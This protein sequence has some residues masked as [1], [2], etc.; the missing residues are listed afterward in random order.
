MWV[1]EAWQD[2]EKVWFPVVWEEKKD[3][4]NIIDY[5]I[6]EEI[7]IDTS[8]VSNANNDTTTGMATVIPWVNA[9]KLIESTSIYKNVPDATWWCHIS[10]TSSYMYYP[11]DP[12]APIRSWNISSERWNVQF[13]NFQTDDPT[14]NWLKFK[15]AWWY[16]LAITRPIWWSTFS[17][18]CEL[19]Y[20][21]S[22]EVIFTYP[23][24][25]NTQTYRDTIKHYFNAWDVIYV[26]CTLTYTWWWW[27]FWTTA[28]VQMDISLL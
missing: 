26:W 27:S 16:N 18:K 28:N 6:H 23:W 3:A 21:P 25:N 11:D 22:R 2:A 13:E 19:R 5:D 9:P 4:S 12:S 10:W 24:H 15:K 8:S 7:T 20:A 1:L 17:I 14:K